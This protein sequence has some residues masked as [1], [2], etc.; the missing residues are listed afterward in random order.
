MKALLLPVSLLTLLS[1]AAFAQDYAIKLHR[2]DKVGET[3]KISSTGKQSQAMNMTVNGTP[4]KNDNKSIEV[5]FEGTEKIVEVSASGEATKEVVTVDKLTMA[6]G[7]AAATDVLPKGTVINAS[8]ADKKQS[9]EV[10]GKP[11]SPE[12]AQALDMVVSLDKDNGATTDD[13]IFGTSEKKKKGDSWD[14]NV[15]KAKANFQAQ[16]DGAELN[17]V[18]GKTT[19]VDVTGDMMSL[20]AQ[21]TGKPKAPLPPM[22]TVDQ[23]ALKATFTASLP[24]DVTKSAPREESESLTMSFAAHADAPSGEKVAMKVEMSQSMT[25]KGTLVK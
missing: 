16:A 1:T 4:Q 13:D 18:T 2:P 14:I 3:Y 10:D 19:L 23:T 11:V 7:G 5:Q 21:I 24:V 22:F 12:A 17:E 8:V 15:E 6:T 25:S 9:Y 20:S